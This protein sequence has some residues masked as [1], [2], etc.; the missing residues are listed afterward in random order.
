MA[1]LIAQDW[2]EPYGGAEKVLAALIEVLPEADLACLW[3]D[4]PRWDAQLRVRESWLARSPMRGRKAFSLPLMSA[5]WRGQWR[6][7]QPDWVVTSSYVF[8][9]HLSTVFPD[10]PRFNY[11]HS[12]ARYLWAA[13]HDRRGSNPLL[14]PASAVL[15]GIDQRAASHNGEIAA[16][17]AFI[18][19]RIQRAWGR[20]ATVIYPPVDVSTIAS[21][22]HWADRLT[23][24]EADLLESLPENEFLLAGSRMVPYKGHA[25]VV[26]MGEALGVPVVLTGS[27]PEEERLR[28]QARGSSTPVFFLGKVSDELLRALYQ[29]AL[30]FVFPPVE[31]F[32]IMPVEAMAAG[33]PVIANRLGGA[34]ESVV[35][36]VTGALIDTAD[37][38]SWAAA[39]DRA[40]S[41][42]R[43]AVRARA[44]EST[45]PGS[46][47]GCGHGSRPVSTVPNPTT[48]MWR[49]EAYC[50]ERRITPDRERR[51]PLL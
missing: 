48:A 42:D 14:G 51:H 33:C 2:V 32:G 20:D 39:V 29:R 37:P 45:S 8:A 13:E 38:K 26:A 1:G 16:N 35:D 6:S 18:R 44:L 50:H 40:T 36:G 17:S 47:N 43:S 24:A 15:R 9:H 11:V 30:A 31:D 41:T 7:V 23:A 4:D 5:T 49:R 34:A 25:Q 12:P 28:E 21:E 10:V 27:G 19:E 46:T 3:N 22:A